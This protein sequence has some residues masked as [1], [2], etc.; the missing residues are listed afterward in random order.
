MG[1]LSGLAGVY[2]ESPVTGVFPIA[3]DGEGGLMNTGSGKSQVSHEA[4]IGVNNEI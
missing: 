2:R 3:A 4:I 1:S